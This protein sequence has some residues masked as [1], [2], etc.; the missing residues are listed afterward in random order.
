MF[1]A[2]VDHGA[3]WNGRRIAVSNVNDLREA[4]FFGLRLIGELAPTALLGRFDWI[5]AAD[6]T[7]G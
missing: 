4:T 2:A 1:Y 3:Y 7:K 5:Y 6:V